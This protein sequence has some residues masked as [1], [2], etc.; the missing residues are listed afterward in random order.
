M[1]SS[2]LIFR[3]ECY[4]S[5]WR[6]RSKEDLSWNVYFLSLRYTLMA[7]PSSFWGIE[8]FPHRT[9]KRKFFDNFTAR[10]VNAFLSLCDMKGVMRKFH[11]PK[12]VSRASKMDLNKVDD[13][14]SNISESF[15]QKP[16]LFITSFVLIISEWEQEKLSVSRYLY[17]GS[18]SKVGWHSRLLSH[19]ARMGS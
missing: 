11:V 17:G 15:A 13:L 16:R 19:Q 18:T 12:F 6:Q 14:T 1:Y 7:L 8:K 3:K 4:L 9:S 2:S 10:C 5:I